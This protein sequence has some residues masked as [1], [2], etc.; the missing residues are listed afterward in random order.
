[1]DVCRKADNPIPPYWSTPL[2]NP[3]P[4]QTAP[5]TAFLLITALPFAAQAS[6]GEYVAIRGHVTEHRASNLE[7]TSPRVSAQIARQNTDRSIAPSL[8]WG[9]VL[10]Y[11]LRIE[12]ELTAPSKD[13]F[14]S[15]WSPF[16]ANANE[17]AVRA[18][19]MMFNLY[20]DLP[21]SDALSFH[22][23]AGLGVV[24]ARADGWQGTVERRF[25]SRSQNNLAYSL[26]AGFSYAVSPGVALDL[27][28][29]YVDMGHVE[30]G[31]NTFVNRIN[32]RDEQ[33]MG[34]LVS[35]EIVL[36]GRVNF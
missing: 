31:F 3:F 21:I 18:Q 16:D 19:R 22:V 29:R 5:L 9:T 25:A 4:R 11:N 32:A 6:G 35:H 14:T 34:D 30:T 17:L 23:G 2:I 26:G 10:A 36:G 20:R 24:R 33:L 12:G 13:R 28:Y 15:H 27:G 8:A 1:V 7:L